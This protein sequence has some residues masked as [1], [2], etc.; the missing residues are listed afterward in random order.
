L[1]PVHQQL[2]R[3]IQVASRHLGQRIHSILFGNT[4]TR[5][6]VGRSG[7]D[8]RPRSVISTSGRFH[9]P[10][11]HPSSENAGHTSPASNIIPAMK[12]VIIGV[13]LGVR[14]VSRNSLRGGTTPKVLFLKTLLVTSFPPAF[15]HATL[16]RAVRQR[17][18][19]LKIRL[20]KPAK[21]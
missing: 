6:K 1:G 14:K 20:G 11:H 18:Q 12:D 7:R 5:T 19:S 13:S 3:R 17:F 8:C 9:D 21:S 10:C 15:R 4:H 16:E 2:Q